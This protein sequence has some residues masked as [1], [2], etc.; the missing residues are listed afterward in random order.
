MEEDKVMHFRKDENVSCK[1]CPR[2]DTCLIKE[3]HG[4]IVGGVGSQD[5]MIFCLVRDLNKDI[6]IMKNVKVDK[7]GYEYKTIVT[8]KD[9]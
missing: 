8:K 9:D 6:E 3:F 2:Y 1:E 7:K 5:D 4:G